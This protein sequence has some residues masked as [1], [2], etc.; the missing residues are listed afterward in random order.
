MKKIVLLFLLLFI[1]LFSAAASEFEEGSHYSRVDPPQPGGLGEQIQVR[2]FFWYGCGACSSLEPHLQG[3]LKRKPGNVDFIRIPMATE[4]PVMDLHA[5]TFYVLELMGAD[6]VI[7]EKIFE[8]I[9][10]QDRKLRTLD[11]MEEFLAEEGIDVQVYRNTLT[12]DLVNSSIR[13][14]KK[15]ASEK[16]FNVNRVPTVIVD[17]KY[18]AGW[19]G[20]ADTI[21]LTEYLIEK[22]RRE[23]SD[24][25]AK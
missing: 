16:V 7:H 5:R 17:G 20:G 4:N 8:A 13:R 11:E 10:V 23:K 12:I 19:L 3:W 25:A 9:N 24:Q 18:V 1:P 15:L 2:E 22:V 14:A 21:K 6:P